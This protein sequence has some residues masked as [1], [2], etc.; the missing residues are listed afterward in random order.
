MFGVGSVVLFGVCRYE[1]AALEH[2]ALHGGCESCLECNAVTSWYRV[3]V[4]GLLVRQRLRPPALG[5]HLR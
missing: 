5:R 4:A 1:C 2:G 3:C